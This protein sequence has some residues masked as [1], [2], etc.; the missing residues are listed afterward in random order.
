MVTLQQM[1]GRAGQSKHFVAIALFVL[2]TTISA[3][4]TVAFPQVAAA[5]TTTPETKPTVEKVCGNESTPNS[6]EE[7]TAWNACAEKVI[8][9]YNTCNTGGADSTKIAQCMK[10]GLGDTAKNVSAQDLKAAVEA[11]KTA[12]TAEP[13]T[14]EE[15]KAKGD[16]WEWNA[17]TKKC[18]EKGATPGESECSVPGGM[19]WAIC[20]VMM[21]IASLND[22]LYAAAA[23]MLV[24]DTQMF[25]TSKD[26]PYP[27]WQQFQTIANIIFIIGFVVIV[28]SQI[29]GAG[30]S[31][32]GIKKMLPKLIVIAILVN[33]SYFVCQLA[34][35]VSN[36]L[37]VSLKSVFDAIATRDVAA[38]DPKTEGW[39]KI[40]S[41]ALATAGAAILL[42]AVSA[43]VLLAAFL[44]L[45]MIVLILIVRKA[46]IILLIVVSPVAFALYLLPNTEQWTKKW[47]K[48]FF[49][50]LM[51]FPII[52]V[53]FGA[54][55]LASNILMKIPGDNTTKIV[56]L[57]AG[58]LPLFIVPGLL[59]A[60]LSA[61][62]KLGAKMQGWGDKA[63]GR[64]GAK[65]RETS[66]L[67]TALSD[68]SKY[69][70]QQ[71]AIKLAKGRNRGVTGI[72]ARRAGGRGYG[73][74]LSTQAASLEDAEFTEQ[75][76]AASVGFGEMGSGDV[77]NRFQ[78]GG[79]SEAEQA[80]AIEHIMSKGSFNERRALV[81]ASGGMSQRLKKRVSEGVYAKGDQK[82]YGAGIG[83]QIM[84]QEG[85][86]GAEGV[87]NAA[88][89]NINTGSIGAEDMVH[90][91]SATKYLAEV[92]ASGK[93]TNEG[94]G[95]MAGAI[96]NVE[97][98]PALKGKVTQAYQSQFDSINDTHR[99]ASSPSQ[100][101]NHPSNTPPSSTP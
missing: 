82:I 45:A 81:E 25:D 74:K 50:L 7:V 35:D 9:Q 27:A 78:A 52:A 91:E 34:V 76:K 75:V 24:V 84:S 28:Y 36:L 63:T 40:V 56:A 39:M 58:A 88:A 44:A 70:S 38:V 11:G 71:R 54:S 21:I 79:L 83:A 33:V 46:L 37:G 19:G 64:V 17:E 72:I 51:L 55:A 41:I 73:D 89:A 23:G 32:Y 62:G 94:L 95:N 26:G 16:T 18:S 90:S 15:C 59:K 100:N 77:L 4:G 60:S 67:G 96:A 65:A 99:Y 53:V 97:S 92:A 43:P 68:A 80:A 20:P 22:T 31:N 57:G 66:R 42:L 1:V 12:A 87:A 85:V 98:T 2:G 93:V 10:S 86:G 14:E 30:L 6:D 29:T 8:S 48:L 49:S 3:L 101:P 5:V 47:G 13:K 61:T 69:R